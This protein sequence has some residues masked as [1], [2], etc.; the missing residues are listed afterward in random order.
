L[1]GEVV[2]LTHRQHIPLYGSYDPGKV[3][4]TADAFIDLNHIDPM[5][6][7]AVADLLR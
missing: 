4:L 6:F 2:A 5:H 3:G 1:E 7:D